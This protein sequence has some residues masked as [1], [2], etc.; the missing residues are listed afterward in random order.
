MTP[1]KAHDR[2]RPDSRP[3]IITGDPSTAA[4]V[5]LGSIAL[6]GTSRAS[7]SLAAERAALPQ[8]VRLSVLNTSP[9]S[10]RI[11]QRADTGTSTSPPP[12]FPSATR[13][14]SW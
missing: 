6:E 14:D 5:A 9:T 1:A 3:E 10:L 8:L 4:S 11:N 13:P 7:R 2:L 12:A